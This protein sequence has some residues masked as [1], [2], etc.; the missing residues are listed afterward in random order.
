MNNKKK[1]A[2]YCRVARED[3][4][5][6][7]MQEAVLQKFAE[8]NHYNNISVYADNGFNGLNFN[9]PAFNR[10]NN[11]ISA[12][13]IET[14]IIKYVSRISRNCLDLFKWVDNIRNKGVALKS[15]VDDVD[16]DYLHEMT[17]II[18]QAY[19][20]YRA[21]QRAQNNVAH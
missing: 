21:N 8:E 1:V 13:I 9:R 20:K 18:Q 12:G 2:I 4:E 6:I 15:I 11:D 14:V 3:D 10:L 16:N 7:K 5:I 17:I 19:K